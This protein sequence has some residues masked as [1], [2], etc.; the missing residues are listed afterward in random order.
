[1][2]ETKIVE[3]DQQK[4]LKDE[5]W[6]QEQQERDQAQYVIEK[7]KQVIVES[8]KSQSFLEKN[9]KLSPAAFA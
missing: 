7:A 5:E 1:L 4:T 6:A 3:L 8:L 9:K 2:I